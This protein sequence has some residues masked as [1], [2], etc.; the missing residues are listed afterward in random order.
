MGLSVD[1]EASS[2]RQRIKELE[3][4]LG[5]LRESESRL[6]AVFEALPFAVALVDPNGRVVYGNREWVKMYPVKLA[7]VK[8]PK[9]PLPIAMKFLS[10]LR[11]S[12]VRELARDKNVPSGIQI[13]ARKAMEKKN[14]PKKTGH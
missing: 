2:L 8:N 6:Q 5:V 11:E 14:E 9:V 12:E 10:T 13:Q 7:L 3:D 1:G 4:A